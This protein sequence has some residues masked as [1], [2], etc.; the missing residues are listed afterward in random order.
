M[1]NKPCWQT[2]ANPDDWFIS[3]DGKQ[4]PDE[5]FLTD[6]EKRAIGKTVLGLAGESYDDHQAR[7]ARAIRAVEADR[8]RAA[9]QRRRKAKEACLACPMRDECLRLALD[10]NFQHGTWGGLY[11]EELRELRRRISARKRGPLNG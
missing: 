10:G 1:T 7:V 9:L 3:R 6:A 4:Y 5:E 11:E 2:G 8:R